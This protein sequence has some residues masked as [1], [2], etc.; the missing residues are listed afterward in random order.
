MAQISRIGLQDDIAISL[1]LVSHRIGSELLIEFPDRPEGVKPEDL[2]REIASIGEQLGKRINL[3]FNLIIC[4]GR[5]GMADLFLDLKQSQSTFAPRGE[6][7]PYLGLYLY[8]KALEIPNH[9]LSLLERM[10]RACQDYLNRF[11]QDK[12]LPD[13]LKLESPDSYPEPRVEL[14]H[15]KFENEIKLLQVENLSHNHRKVVMRII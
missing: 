15:L 2:K 11:L 5:I 6:I 9:E 8:R 4:H 13:N 7:S 3:E 1:T 12:N 14:F 10:S